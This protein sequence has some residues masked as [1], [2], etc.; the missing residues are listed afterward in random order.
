[1]VRSR[2]GDRGIRSSS[3]PIP[4][5]PGH[6]TAHIASMAGCGTVHRTN[7]DTVNV[8]RSRSTSV[9]VRLPSLWR[10]RLAHS[11]SLPSARLLPDDS[12]N[13]KRT[14][15]SRS[16]GHSVLGNSVHYS[17]LRGSRQSHNF[18]PDYSAPSAGVLLHD[19]LRTTGRGDSEIRTRG[20]AG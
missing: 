14:I 5:I 13:I 1:M 15:C 12:S 10:R 8:S 16:G 18:L 4:S 19:G 11:H 2:S 3:F 20:C 9:L 7:S 6:L 17:H